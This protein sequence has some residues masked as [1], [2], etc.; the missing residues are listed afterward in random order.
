MPRPKKKP[1]PND[2][3]MTMS[4]QEL[5]DFVEAQQKTFASV[6]NKRNFV[7]QERELIND[8]YQISKT[9]QKKLEDKIKVVEYEMDELNKNHNKEIEAFT[10]KFK[11]LEYD[12]ET[13]ITKTLVETSQTAVKHEEEERDKREKAYI[14]KKDELKTSIKDN[15]ARNR[16]DI[17]KKQYT[18]KTNYENVK[19]EM[20]EKQAKL[21]AEYL[22][23]FKFKSYEEKL[24][25]TEADLELRLRVVIHELEE[26]KNLHYNNLKDAFEKRMN[27]WK[28]ENIKQIKENINLI[29]LNN[30]AHCL[31]FNRKISSN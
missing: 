26:R 7:Q 6:K 20:K 9:E 21:R 19:K 30:V 5:K 28:E 11:H 18:Q 12:H 17:E 1:E 13:F 14:A 27:G 16:K 24:R 10:N 25:E 31:I 8:Y 15:A 22:F 3:F 4:L 29:K 23:F 2:N